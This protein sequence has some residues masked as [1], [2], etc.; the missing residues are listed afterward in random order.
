[1]RFLRRWRAKSLPMSA[2]GVTDVGLARS[3]NQDDFMSLLGRDAP[4]GDALFAVADG[5]GGHSAG[6]VASRIALE[7]LRY[8]LSNASSPTERTLRRA[9]SIANKGVYSE[10]TMVPGLR[11][12]GTTLVVGLVMDGMM[13]ICNIGDSR[14]YLLREG[15]LKQITK[16]HSWVAEMVDQGL[17]TPDQAAVHPRQNMITRALGIGE[18]VQADVYRV[19]L[20]KNDRVLLCSDGLHGLVD[21]AEIASLLAGKSLKGAAGELVKS[22][23]RAGGSDNITVIVAQMNS[24][25]QSVQSDSDADDSP[26]ITLPPR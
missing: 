23:N 5:M 1:M 7:L 15:T 22:A 3:V 18:S 12:M 11:G 4:I 13:I 21:D 14:A 19:P 26:A 8:E 2:I 20:Q 25:V 16:D 9:V 24:E 6:E 10:S 17:L